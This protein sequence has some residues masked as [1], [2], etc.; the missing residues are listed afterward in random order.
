MSWLKDSQLGEY[1]IYNKIMVDLIDM[2]K[3]ESKYSIDVN[4]MAQFDDEMQ[5]SC[6][7]QRNFL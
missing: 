2:L 4:P 1:D 6:V 7:M 5:H 3:G